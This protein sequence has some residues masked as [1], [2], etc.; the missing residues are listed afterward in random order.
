GPL[1]PSTVST[2]ASPEASESPPVAPPPDTASSTAL[3]I[4]FE[5]TVAPETV[6]TSVELLSTIAAGT[7][8]IAG[9]AKPSV[10]ACSVTVT[11]VIVSP[12]IV[13]A[14]VKGPLWPSAV[15]T[16]ASAGASSEAPESDS[17][18]ENVSVNK[19]VTTNIVNRE[20]T[21]IFNV[22]LVFS[23]ILYILSVKELNYN[24]KSSICL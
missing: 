20:A 2:T 4:A 9:S 7:S 8:S 16:K 6:S 21:I 19:N 17:P 24:P 10:S 11:S 15:P 13:T 12:S 22:K 18:N 3:I 5:V 1:W 23:P 14:T